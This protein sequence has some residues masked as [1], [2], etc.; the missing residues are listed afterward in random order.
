L[1]EAEAAAGQW[2]QRVPQPEVTLPEETP[3][4][5]SELYQRALEFVKSEFEENTWRAFWRTAVDG[6]SAAETA[7]ELG[8]SSPPCAWPSRASCTA[9]A[10]KSAI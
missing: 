10:R 7:A 9:S 8:M 2:M 3:Q 1:N 6:Q 5:M 4:Q